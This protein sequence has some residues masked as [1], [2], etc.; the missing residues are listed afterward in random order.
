MSIRREVDKE[1]VVHI[2]N[3][4][5]LSNKKEQNN[6]IFSSPDGPK[7]CHTNRSKVRHRKISV[8]WHRLYVESK[9]KGCFWVAKS[10]L[11]LCA[12]TYCS[13]PGSSIHGISQAGILECVVI[14]FSRGSSQPRDRTR[15]SCIGRWILYCW[16][17]R[18]VPPKEYI[19]QNR[20]RGTDV[21]NTERK[22]WKVGTDIYLY[23]IY[24]R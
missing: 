4:M 22:N 24:N 15:I 2:H 12:P 11:T 19:S 10:H 14:S 5:L 16:A 7:D 21:E 20:S 3:G 6:T 8:I 17:S 13:P 1:D 18:E 9:K 23:Y